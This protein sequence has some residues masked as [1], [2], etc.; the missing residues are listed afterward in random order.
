[1]DDKIRGYARSGYLLTFLDIAIDEYSN[2][3]SNKV[4][5]N[6]IDKTTDHMEFEVEGK[7]VLGTYYIN[8]QEL[9]EVGLELN[10]NV[11]K[12]VVFLAMYVEAYIWDFA[13][14]VF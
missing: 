14:L 9:N 4:L 13:A 1:M 12:I 10:K 8:N 7:T 11:I 3:K 5:L 6:K 2:Y